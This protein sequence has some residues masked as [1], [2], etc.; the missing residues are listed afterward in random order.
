MAT[1]VVAW[2][3]VGLTGWGIGRSD[4]P[5]VSRGFFT[6]YR[7]TTAANVRR[8]MA[9]CVVPGRNLDGAGAGY[10]EE[11]KEQIAGGTHLVRVDCHSAIWH[12]RRADREFLAAALNLTAGGVTLSLTSG[13]APV[14]MGA[15]GAALSGE[16]GTSGGF[17]ILTVS[18][19]PPNRI[20]VR[21]HERVSITDGTD[22]ETARALRVTSSNGSGEAV[23]RLSEAMTI[24]EGKVEIGGPESIVFEAMDLP[25]AVQPYRGDWAYTWQFREV[26]AAEVGGFTEVDPW[27]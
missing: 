26:F 15:G 24:A 5:T 3:P 19:L 22:T 13:G 1:T 16:P 6:N 7:R 18:G 27:R 17:P 11:L 8:R 14:L 10:M 23:I 2:P 20:V 21:P 4:G 9:T 12:L 25:Q